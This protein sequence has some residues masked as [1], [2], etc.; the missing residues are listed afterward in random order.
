MWQLS[1]HLLSPSQNST[2]TGRDW[3]ELLPL[4]RLH[5]RLEGDETGDT[6]SKVLKVNPL[7]V[8]TNQDANALAWTV[9]TST[10]TMA[11]VKQVSCR[12]FCEL[13]AG[14]IP[15]LDWRKL[16]NKKCVNYTGE[17][18]DFGESLSWKRVE[19]GLP[20][21][22]HCAAVNA[23][24]LAEGSMREYLQHP[25]RAVVDLSTLRARP[26][27]GRVCVDRSDVITLFRGLLDR[28]LI[29]V[30]EDRDCLRVCGE[31]L[32]NGLF[33]VP[34]PDSKV[35]GP[36]GQELGTTQRLIMN[37]T[38]SNQVFADCP[39][40]IETLPTMC[41]WRSII[42]PPESELCL[43]WEDLKGAF[44][45]LALP[46]C[47]C[48]YFL[49]NIELSSRQLHIAGPD[50]MVRVGARV[51]P[52]GWK[53]A[54]GICQYL[55]RRMVALSVGKPGH[56]LKAEPLPLEREARKDKQFP[57]LSS[58]ARYE[59]R[60]LQALWQLYIDDVDM[61]ELRPRGAQAQQT[62]LWQADLR[63]RYDYWSA[64]RSESKAGE[65][66]LAAKRLGFWV[67]GSSGRLGIGGERAG[68]LI[69]L[70]LHCLAC[71]R[72]SKRDIQILSGLWAHAIQFRR[73]T[74]TVF[75][76]WWAVA[77]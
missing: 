57:F 51:I 41:T 10:C 68:K 39:A 49:F 50:R 76:H 9:A 16:L 75:S 20:P 17:V 7:H 11:E 67:D 60:N 77:A 70:S 4:P 38:A 42:I 22:H 8:L 72:L 30:V 52:M 59:N 44:Y 71:L 40:D 6:W 29:G 18:L 43:S 36:D 53:G 48:K 24:L 54:V 55:H 45:L 64:A 32:A 28:G 23:V 62:P 1:E 63:E 61:I 58:A 73:E 74:A 69:G 65:Q 47:W 37:L 15:S 25:E 5:L 14:V 56:D 13:P 46:E 19:P 26:R 12:Y 2:Q 34:K 66:E 31:V 3:R 27:P 35:L 33:G 21:F